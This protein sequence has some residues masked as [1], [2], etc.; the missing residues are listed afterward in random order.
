VLGTLSPLPRRMEWM[1]ADVEAVVARSQLVI[2][3]PSISLG[4]DIGMVRGMLL[5]PS[6]F[7]ARRNPDGRRL[8]EAV[9]AEL[10]SR[11]LPLKARYL[12]RNGKVEEWRPLF[13]AQE[14]YEAAMRQSGLSQDN[15]VAPLVTKAAKRHGVPVTAPTVALAVA[16]PKAVIR[17]F[18]ASTLADTECFSRTMAR[19]EVDL[20]AMRARANAWAV[21]DIGALRALPQDDQ[22]AACVRAVT[23]TA[24]ARKLGASDL[25]TR[26][27]TAW[28]AAAET[29]VAS[30]EVSFAML[31]V[32]ELLR[33]DGYL[34]TLQAKGYEVVAP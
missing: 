30:H 22:Y 11:W 34:A 33:P 3:P 24:L 6:L 21:G 17:E 10:Y 13:A 7:R 12:A 25:R 29:A 27:R 5:L 1:S 20:E 31:P 14:L 28:L 8:R 23:E 2:K 18:N 16:D 19:I 9:P 26:V 32:S 15:I 4:S